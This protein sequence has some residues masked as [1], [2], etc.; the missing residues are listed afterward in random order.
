MNN[1]DKGAFSRR[2][3]DELISTCNMLEGRAVFW[4]CK[5]SL[6]PNDVFAMLVPDEREHDALLLASRLAFTSSTRWTTEAV[7]TNLG[8]PKTRLRAAG[9]SCLPPVNPTDRVPCPEQLGRV[10]PGWMTIFALLQVHE[11]ISGR[12]E[13]IRKALTELHWKCANPAQ[14]RFYLHALPALLQF[15]ETTKGMANSLSEFRVPQSVPRI[16]DDTRDVCCEAST[17]VTEA[18]LYPAPDDT[19]PNFRVELKT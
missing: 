9:V 1:S 10:H 15:S 7:L 2:V 8:F 6:V 12:W 4:S 17:W 16:G 18:L 19:N 11:E 3:F 5:L 14:V 13:M